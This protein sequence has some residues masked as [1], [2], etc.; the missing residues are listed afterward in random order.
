MVETL[1]CIVVVGLIAALVG[2]H[3]GRHTGYCDGYDDGQ[4]DAAAGLWAMALGEADDEEPRQPIDY[5][6]GRP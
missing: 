5:P 6:G 2:W 4:D 1:S 3:T